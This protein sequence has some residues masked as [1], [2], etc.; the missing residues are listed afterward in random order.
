MTHWI[1]LIRDD[2]V[3]CQPLGA[4]GQHRRLFP[5]SAP[6]VL[7]LTHDEVAL[8]HSWLESRAVKQRWNTLLAAAKEAAQAEDLLR[9]LL[10]HGWCELELHVQ[11][12]DGLAQWEPGWVSW[13][14]MYRLRHLAESADVLPTGEMV[15][16]WKGWQPRNPELTELAR[17][18]NEN[19]HSAVLERQLKL[20]KGLD[21]WLSRGQWGTE[22]MFSLQALGRAKTFNDG[23]RQWLAEFGIDLP[24]C[25]IANG[26]PHVWLAGPLSLWQGGRC[27]LDKAACM[28]GVAI[29]PELLLSADKLEGTPCGIRVVQSQGVFESLRRLDQ[30]GITLWVQGRLHRGWKQVFSY[31]LRC[32][33]VPVQLSCNLDPMGVQIAHELGTLVE[34]AGLPWHLWYMDEHWL[35]PA[36]GAQPL[37]EDDEHVLK[38]LRRSGHLLAKL[39]PLLEQ[40][41]ER[42]LKL[43]QEVLFIGTVYNMDNLT[44]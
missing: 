32:F 20:A 12:H 10:E 25:G 27:V 42:Q 13:L 18:L 2:K 17:S 34:Q 33:D 36:H 37:T 5:R 24:A 19:V 14:D 9:R 38:W 43:D 7:P 41:G 26:S 31:L 1:T 16:L 15:R 6:V 23:D 35:A 3:A 29:S 8:I 4:R 40:I 39:Q 21:D 30:P 28:T 44:T 22:K 11:W